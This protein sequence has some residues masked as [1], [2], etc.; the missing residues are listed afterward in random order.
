MANRR[1]SYS[2]KR[3][4]DEL[5]QGRGKTR[6][7]VAQRCKILRN[8]SVK[9]I[10]EYKAEADLAIKLMGIACTGYSDQVGRARLPQSRRRSSD[11]AKSTM[12]WRR[13]TMSDV[14]NVRMA[15]LSAPMRPAPC[16]E[17]IT[18]SPK[19]AAS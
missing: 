4:H 13:R 8:L 6:P 3:L 11:A 10:E 17:A 14:S 15:P 18:G 12:V 16:G 19:D 9:E 7:A 5:I 2:V 1:G